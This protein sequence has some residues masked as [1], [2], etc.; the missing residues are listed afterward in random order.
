M[1]TIRRAYS[2]LQS[3]TIK[4][5][6]LPAKIALALSPD[7]IGLLLSLVA[8]WV[9]HF[10][11]LHHHPSC[12]IPHTLSVYFEQDIHRVLKRFGSNIIFFNGLRDP[13]SGGGY[14]LSQLFPSSIFLIS[15]TTVFT[16]NSRDNFTFCEN[17]YHVNGYM[18]VC[19][20]MV[21]VINVIETV[22]SVYKGLGCK[23]YTHYLFELLCCFVRVLKSISKSIVAIV[24]KEG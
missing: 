4:L 17:E 5:G 1:E 10:S 11:M 3:G 2:Q 20:L 12:S 16:I 18:T 21:V 9:Y 14:H 8:M 22:M 13:W 7:P 6:S 23:S 15:S 19:I 24:A